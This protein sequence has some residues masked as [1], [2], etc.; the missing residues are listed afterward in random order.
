MCG[1]CVLA[2]C[3]LLQGIFRGN[4]L[5]HWEMTSCG[6]EGWCLE[7]I[8][9]N[10]KWKANEMNLRPLQMV[11]TLAAMNLKVGEEIPKENTNTYTL[12]CVCIMKKKKE[13]ISSIQGHRLPH[14][15]CPYLKK[16]IILDISINSLY[17]E[18]R[19]QAAHAIKSCIVAG[20]Q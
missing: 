5:D 10:I 4:P 14:Q 12:M 1:L 8:K 20:K 13:S 17:L 6:N 15:K 11:P 19:S 3:H 18:S 2:L 16:S 9:L 7:E